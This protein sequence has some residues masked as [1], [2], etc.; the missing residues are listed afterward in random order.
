MSDS[1]TH[2]AE[3]DSKTVD[4]EGS[5]E[6][7]H[8]KAHISKMQSLPDGI[9]RS[10]QKSDSG[11]ASVSFKRKA[12]KR[13]STVTTGEDLDALVRRKKMEQ[14]RSQRR[15]SLTQNL[16]DGNL[17]I[18]INQSYFK[19]EE[20]TSGSEESDEEQDDKED[21]DK[22]HDADAEA[23]RKSQILLAVGV[24]VF[25]CACQAPFEA[26]NK[27]DRGCGDLISVTQY[28][29]GLVASAPGAMQ[30]RAAAGGWKISWLMHFGLAVAN[31]GYFVMLNIVLATSLPLPVI[32]TMKNG[33]LVANLVVGVAL[34]RRKYNFQQVTAV[35]VVTGGLVLTALTGTQQKAGDGKGEMGA[36]AL[37]GVALLFGALVARALNGALQEMCRDAPVSELLF[38][39]SGIGLPFFCFE[40]QYDIQPRDSLES[41]GNWWIG[42]AIHVVVASGESR[43]RLP[44][45][46]SDDEVDWGDQRINS[47]DGS[48]RAALYRL[49][50]FCSG[51]EPIPWRY[52]PSALVWECFDLTRDTCVLNCWDEKGASCRA[53]KE[54]I[55]N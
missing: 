50:A 26:L 42:L 27:Y 1:P 40:G 37:L 22:K 45:E 31:L 51:L 46:S 55:R 53:K 15:A 28:V 36:D 12:L 49:R 10:L 3:N 38:M 32:I 48:H 24:V 34:M 25:G 54:R 2:E 52:K 17:D 6:S 19:E 47:D 33:N 13:R 41:V 16:M 23:S 7:V 8:R 18:A 14:M 5:K 30:G 20:V 11:L 35:L 4:R 21:I 29:Y 9:G 44:Y 43:F 39:G